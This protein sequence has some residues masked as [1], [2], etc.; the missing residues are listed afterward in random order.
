MILVFFVNMNAMPKEVIDSRNNAMQA[1]T[2]TRSFELILKLTDF[3]MSNL[4]KVIQI[5]RFSNLFEPQNIFSVPAINTNS[6]LPDEV[7]HKGAFSSCVC[8]HHD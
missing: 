6:L 2:S 4:S 7:K 5:G 8:L 3:H 1:Q